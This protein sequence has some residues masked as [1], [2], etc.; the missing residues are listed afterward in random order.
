MLPPFP[1]R[2]QGMLIRQVAPSV[3]R[4]GGGMQIWGEQAYADGFFSLVRRPRWAD[5]LKGVLVVAGKTRQLPC[6][7]ISC[8][9]FCLEFMEDSP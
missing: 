7:Y 4:G 5:L 8:M 6:V 9:S 1:P 2:P 3:P